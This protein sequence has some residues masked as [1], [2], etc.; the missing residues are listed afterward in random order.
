MRCYTAFIRIHFLWLNE[1]YWLPCNVLPIVCVCVF[2]H[3]YCYITIRWDIYWIF[4]RR[5]TDFYVFN[6]K[7]RRKSN[8]TGWHENL[9]QLIFSTYSNCKRCN[10]ARYHRTFLSALFAEHSGGGSDRS[11]GVEDSL[12]HHN[13]DADGS[14][15][16]PAALIDFAQS[17]TYCAVWQKRHFRGWD[18]SYHYAAIDMTRRRAA[19]QP[20]ALFL[21]SHWWWAS[22]TRTT[23]AHID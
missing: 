3:R 18:P 23:H 5:T 22:Y 4:V 20:L 10:V 9:M 19:C 11:L 7:W 13:R 1:S 15:V 16:R 21:H 14:V 12:I 17:E 8:K 2:A 6:G